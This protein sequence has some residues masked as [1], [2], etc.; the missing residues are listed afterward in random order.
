MTA[1]EKELERILSEY[2]NYLKGEYQGIA[3][4]D[5][6]TAKQAL[7]DWYNKSLSKRDEQYGEI[8]RWLF[9]EEGDFPAS[10]VGKRYN[11]RP[12]LRQK[13]ASLNQKESKDE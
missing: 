4:Y 3:D 10:E 5:Y 8:F 7:I 13:L 2:T 12:V 1:S 9:G 6:A 11:W